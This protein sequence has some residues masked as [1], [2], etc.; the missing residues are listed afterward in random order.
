MVKSKTK[1]NTRAARSKKKF[2]PA[3]GVQAA[4]RPTFK[5]NLSVGYNRS[6]MRIHN[7]K[8]RRPHRS[9]RLTKRRDYNRSF[10]M[11][12]YFAFSNYVWRELFKSKKT[13]MLLVAFAV[14]A[15]S[16]LVGAMSQN[17]YREFG[18]ALDQTADDLADGQLGQ[19]GRAG[20][21]LLTTA[22][23]GGLNQAP[24]EVQQIFTVI[25]FLVLW[26]VT[27]WLLRYQLS[28]VKV[29]LRDALYNACAPIISTAAVVLILFIQL[30]PALISFIV[31]SAAVTT[32][33]LDTPFY[34]IIF[35]VLAIGLC[36]LSLFL[37]TGSLFAL[38]RVTVPGEY[39]FNAIKISGDLVTSRRLRLILRL[40]WMALCVVVLW[41]VTMLPIILLDSWLT[42][43]FG[44]D[45]VPIVPVALLIVSSISIIFVAA[46][47]YL[48]YR[49]LIDDDADPA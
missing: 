35:W 22:A 48:L 37:V 2:A 5:Q 43:S 9:F 17:T 36:S 49:K 40:F 45:G 25:I 28:D 15:F 44:W 38:V 4:E 3:K 18:K 41:L 8:T 24:T 20:M 19:V 7:Y 30:A 29:R 14:L 34:A 26:L 46:Y 13:F 39:P 23:T 42:S 12:G 16:L 47:V 33:F 10:K 32:G 11:P 6:K 27:V 31:Y 1:K 21:L